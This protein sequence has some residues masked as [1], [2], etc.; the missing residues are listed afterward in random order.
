MPEPISLAATLAIVGGSQVLSGIG[1]Y[2]G[3][4]SE[5]DFQKQLLKR[6]QDFTAKENEANR[7]LQRQGLDF[8]KFQWEDSAPQRNANVMQSLMPYQQ[9]QDRRRF[10]DTGI[11]TISRR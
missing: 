1:G 5:E 9:V 3:Q 4:Q 8:N 10:L 2:F 6:Q 11:G 7:Q